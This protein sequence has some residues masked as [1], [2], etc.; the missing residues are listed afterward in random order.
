MFPRQRRHVL[1]FLEHAREYHRCF[2]DTEVDMSAVKHARTQHRARGER[3]GTV[4][5]L[6]KATALAIRKYPEANVVIDHG[7][8]PRAR[9]LASIDCKIVVDRELAVVQVPHLR[10]VRRQRSDEGVVLVGAPRDRQDTNE[11]PQPPRRGIGEHPRRSTARPGASAD[12]IGRSCAVHHA[13]PD[14]PLMPA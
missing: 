6:A 10:A 4:A 11:W 12:A 8:F 13:H 2:I 1:Y 3:V 9:K 5:I 7:I 14:Q